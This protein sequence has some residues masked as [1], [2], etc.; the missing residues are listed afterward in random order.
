[1]EAVL[2]QLL[3]ETRNSRWFEI[4]LS[5]RAGLALLRCARAH[6]FIEARDFVAP[7]DVKAVFPALSRHRLSPSG[8]SQDPGEQVKELLDQVPIP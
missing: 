2:G 8:F 4:G 5:P 6:A 7:E 1:M 3:A